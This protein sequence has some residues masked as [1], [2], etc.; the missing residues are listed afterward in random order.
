M[1]DDEKPTMKWQ[2]VPADSGKETFRIGRVGDE[3]VAEWVGHATLRAH[4]TNGSSTLTFTDGVDPRWRAKLERGLA[5]AMLRQLR[6]ELT[7]HASAVAIGERAVLLLGASGAGK[8]TLAAFL[9]R[10]SEINLLA[11]D[12]SPISFEA[13][14]AFVRTG[15]PEPWL[16]ADA[17]AAL[18][19]SDT[20]AGKRP[21]TFSS[22][23][24]KQQKIQAIV[25]LTYDDVDAA[26]LRPLRGHAALTRLLEGTVRFVVDEKEIQLRE[27]SQLEQLIRATQMIEM[28]RPRDLSRIETSANAIVDLL[29]GAP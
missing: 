10:R 19:L 15:D 16:L 23:T 8:S 20:D 24:A 17:R 7:L 21:V 12:T 25:A 9:A 11:D 3:L 1:S 27:I 28:I 2:T 6:G 26:T 14:D 22:T 5:S 29:R 4:R 13:D 18:G